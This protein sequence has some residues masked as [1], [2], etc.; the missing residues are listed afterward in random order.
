MA[1]TMVVT[2]FASQPNDAHFKD[3]KM[4]QG[5]DDKYDAISIDVIDINNDSRNQS[6]DLSLNFYTMEEF[7]DFLIAVE[8]APKIKMLPDVFISLNE[9]NSS[10][11]YNGSSTGT[12]WIPFVN[13]GTGLF[14]WFHTDV[15][16]TYSY[17]RNN[18]PYF[19]NATGANSY[20]S[21]ISLSSWTQTSATQN[22]IN[23]SIQTGVNG[24]WYIGIQV[25]GLQLGATVRDSYYW[26]TYWN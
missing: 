13:S 20:I 8:N 5:L 14:C 16:Y 24:T 1:S 25:S 7:E 23:N 18:R 11:S 17:D 3:I 22:V 12:K 19:I 4:I 2:S 26:N 9:N 15:G 10:K 6:N 21:G